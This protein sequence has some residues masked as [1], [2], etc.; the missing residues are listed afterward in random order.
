MPN[1][2]ITYNLNGKDTTINFDFGQKASVFKYKICT[3]EGMKAE[4]LEYYYKDVP[5]PDNKL[6]SEIF[7]G[8]APNP[9]IKI[10][11]IGIGKILY[12]DN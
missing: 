3:A 1:L 8:A 9:K 5:M 4:S 10:L 12:I 11:A 7:S 6:L 2:P